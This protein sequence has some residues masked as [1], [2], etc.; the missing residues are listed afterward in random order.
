MIQY[1]FGM[2]F[3]LGGMAIHAGV[4]II[5]GRSAALAL[6]SAKRIPVQDTGGRR[7]ETEARKEDELLWKR[8]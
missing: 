6:K 8:K 4:I 3:A 2:F 5:A 7:G 1:E